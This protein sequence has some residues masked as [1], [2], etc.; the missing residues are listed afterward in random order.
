MPPVDTTAGDRPDTALRRVIVPLDGSEL[1]ERAL[2]PAREV[3]AAAH[4]EIA[5]MTVTADSRYE[6]RLS[7]LKELAGRITATRPAAV[8]RAPDPA[9]SIA[10]FGDHDDALLVM[11]TH[12]RGGLRRAVLGSVAAETVGMLSRPVLLVGPRCQASEELAGRVLVCLDGS[13]GAESILVPASAWC[14]QFELQPW[15]VTVVTGPRSPSGTPLTEEDAAANLERI[16]ARLRDEG[17]HPG[18]EVVCHDSAAGPLV[19]LAMGL[20]AAIVA[21]TTHRR[22]DTDQPALGATAAR[23][24]HDAPCPVLLGQP[25]ECAASASDQ[26]R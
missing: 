2:G 25:G 13:P 3:A 20:P 26:G 10:E 16:A 14:H 1:A 18:H 6:E 19:A 11:S 8:V 17:L 23:M 24:V 22:A 12:G 5:L 4:A 7:Y 21:L 15:L 9:R